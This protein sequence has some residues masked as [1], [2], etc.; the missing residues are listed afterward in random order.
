MLP[1]VT[2]GIRVATI[3]FT[4]ERRPWSSCASTGRSNHS[5]AIHRCPCSGI[6]GTNRGSP[7]RNLVAGGS[8]RRLHD[9]YRWP[10]HPVLH[11]RCQRRGRPFGYDY[12]GARTQRESSGTEGVA[13]LECP[14]MRLLPDRPGHAG[15]GAAGD[16]Q[17]PLRDGDHR[18]HERQH[19]PLW[20]LPAH[21]R[22][23]Q[24]SRHGSVT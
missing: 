2:W 21:H 13:P 18:C 19:P 24:G 11:H 6:C 3:G 1:D 5:M 9:P 20:L 10:G 12:R 15:R 22:R 4:R 17:K 14:A 16:E 8:L 23:H 7:E